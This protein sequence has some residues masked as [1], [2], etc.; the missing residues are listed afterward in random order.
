MTYFLLFRSPNF[1]FCK[2]CLW[3]WVEL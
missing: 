1:V 3:L 2:A